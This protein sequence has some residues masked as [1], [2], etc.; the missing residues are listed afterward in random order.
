[1]MEENAG[2]PAD[3]PSR[4]RFTMLA[5]D[6]HAVTHQLQDLIAHYNANCRRY[7]RELA[8]VDDLRSELADEQSRF[9]DNEYDEGERRQRVSVLTERFAGLTTPEPPGEEDY[10]AQRLMLE[11]K[12][13]ESAHSATSMLVWQAR[14]EQN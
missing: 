5:V 8:T 1:M 4:M 9:T 6:N 7:V 3:H 10:Q 14:K 13:R 12:L 2:L 11:M